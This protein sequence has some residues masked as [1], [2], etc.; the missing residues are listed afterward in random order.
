[1]TDQT[2]LYRVTAPTY[3]DGAFYTAD[4]QP[5]E[6]VRWDGEP[7][8]VMTPLND[9]AFERVRA[10]ANDVKSEGATSESV[11]DVSSAAIIATLTTRAESAEASVKAL[12]AD[13]DAVTAERDGLAAQVAALTVSDPVI[14]DLADVR[15]LPGDSAEKLEAIEREVDEYKAAQV[16]AAAGSNVEPEASTAK[17]GR[18]PDEE[19]ERAEL[20]A[21]F[22]ALGV[23]VFA[24]SATEKLRA[25]LAKIEAET[26]PK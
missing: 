1:M 26:A 9:A 17:T 19:A 15:T 3:L 23:K 8:A 25:K 18:S 6:G 7:N 21:T 20:F 13:L 2:P 24:G 14:D 10:Q 5:A 11:G 12:T 22:K 16:E 4:S